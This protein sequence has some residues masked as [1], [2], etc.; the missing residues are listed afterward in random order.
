MIIDESGTIGW[1]F[2]MLEV[3]ESLSGRLFLQD[4][5]KLLQSLHNASLKVTKTLT[6]PV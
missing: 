1:S 5:Y 6:K 4:F 2:E 3:P